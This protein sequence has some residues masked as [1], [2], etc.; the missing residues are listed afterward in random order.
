MVSKP[1]VI[2]GLI[3][4][5][6][7]IVCCT[8]VLV[9]MSKCPVPATI[10]FGNP[11]R[12]I[13]SIPEVTKIV[14]DAVVS[15]LDTSQLE[16]Q[17][18]PNKL[19]DPYV[20]MLS[21][22]PDGKYLI[23]TIKSGDIIIIN[24][25]DGSAMET[26]D[27][28][29]QKVIRQPNTI[30]WNPVDPS[31]FFVDSYYGVGTLAPWIYEFNI[32]KK[33]ILPLKL[34]EPSDMLAMVSNNEMLI[35]TPQGDYSQGRKAVTKHSVVNVNTMSYKQIAPDYAYGNYENFSPDWRYTARAKRKHSSVSLLITIFNV[36]SRNEVIVDVG[37]ITQ[38]KRDL[39][40]SYITDMLWL[41]DSSGVV[42]VLHN[43]RLGSIT[44][45]KIA[46]DGKVRIIPSKI[47]ILTHSQNGKYL[48]AECNSKYY[49][50]ECK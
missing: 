23:V 45:L 35:E 46:N 22:S 19:S 1:K 43:Y 21:L 18:F 4:G 20:Y 7:V 31:S 10:S 14:P 28:R 40:W 26:F 47:D 2:F 17:G 38:L 12:N 33:Q 41:P 27:K 42:A 48:I 34:K 13:V 3:I 49:L 6:A 36:A 30:C 9:I 39:K 11:K 50:V 37:N 16:K 5:L 44:M 32:L 15:V 25:A 29:S 8:T 24:T